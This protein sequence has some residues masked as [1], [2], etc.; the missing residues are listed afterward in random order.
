[1]TAIRLGVGCERQSMVF[2]IGLAC[3]PLLLLRHRGGVRPEKG[4]SVESI[5]ESERIQFSGLRFVDGLPC[6]VE[7]LQG[8]GAVGE[9]VIRS[10]LTR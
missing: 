10:Y 8:K 1:M 2:I 5:V 4:K 6:F 9:I 7:T 3:I